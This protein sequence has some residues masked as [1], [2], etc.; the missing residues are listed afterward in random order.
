MGEDPHRRPPP[1]FVG[2][3]VHVEV[4]EVLVGDEHRV[5]AVERD[6]LGERARVDDEHRGVRLD[7]HA[8]V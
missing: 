1:E 4:V 7:P 2:E 3:G 8:R 5:R 6:P